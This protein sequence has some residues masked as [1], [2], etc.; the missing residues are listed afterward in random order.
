MAKV[1][2]VTEISNLTGEYFREDGD[3]RRSILSR[4]RLGKVA[5]IAIK[6]L[7]S[8]ITQ[9]QSGPPP[10]FLSHLSYAMVCDAAM[11]KHAAVQTPKKRRSR[12]KPR[13]SEDTGSYQDDV[14][15]HGGDLPLDV[16]I[17]G[18]FDVDKTVALPDAR[19]VL[20]AAGGDEAEADR[21]QMCSDVRDRIADVSEDAYE[22]EM[23][24][25]DCVLDTVGDVLYDRCIESCVLLTEAKA[26]A[27]RA[28][29]CLVLAER[30][31]QAYSKKVE[32]LA[33]A[34]RN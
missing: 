17:G 4:G 31:E 22:K 15:S 5:A 24:S 16:T 21:N 18:G 32:Y 6:R 30:L 7:L 19:A 9:L 13:R 29:Q 2:T 20:G 26:K 14:L 11:D 1:V 23:S 25:C 12:R 33:K 3:M 28:K 10:C 8:R 27:E 34:M